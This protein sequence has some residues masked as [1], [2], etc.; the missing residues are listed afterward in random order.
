MG[1]KEGRHQ[2]PSAVVDE[3][4]VA[5]PELLF[6]GGLMGGIAYGKGREDVM[7]STLKDIG[8]RIRGLCYYYLHFSKK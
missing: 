5:P 8:E 3:E 1:R 2:K 4:D 7:K 6:V